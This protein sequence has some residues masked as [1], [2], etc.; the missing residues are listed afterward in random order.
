MPICEYG[1]YSYPKKCTGKK[2][3]RKRR[4]INEKKDKKA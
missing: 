1:G 4:K 3:D 2:R